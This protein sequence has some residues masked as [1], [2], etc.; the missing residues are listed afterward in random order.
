M[1]YQ[2]EAINSIYSMIKTKPYS[3]QG[4]RDLSKQ[5]KLEYNLF[6]KHH[7]Y[8]LNKNLELSIP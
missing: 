1:S 7:C 5:E 3:G 4:M 2:R 6:G 8:Y